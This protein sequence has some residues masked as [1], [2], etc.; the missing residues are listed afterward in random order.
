MHEAVNHIR[1][2]R[3]RRPT[4]ARSI[5]DNQLESPSTCRY[6]CFVQ[7]GVCRQFSSEM[8]SV[9][10]RLPA[11]LGVKCYVLLSDNV[12]MFFYQRSVGGPLAAMLGL[13]GSIGNTYRLNLLSS[14]DCFNPFKR[15][16]F[17]RTHEI[18]CR[19]RPS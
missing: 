15:G 10:T 2:S 9:R 13:V 7:I 14:R 8:I 16:E 4:P 5:N 12:A 3:S 17:R 1:S 11:A 18:L 6:A 19:C